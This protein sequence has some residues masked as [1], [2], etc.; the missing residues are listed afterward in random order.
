MTHDTPM[1]NQETVFA[2]LERLGIAYETVDC[3]PEFADTASFCERYD[4]ALADS[5]NT[6]VVAS[7]KP[8]GLFAA[9]VVLATTRLDVNRV[10]RRRLGA[11]RASFA[12][13]EQTTQITGMMIGG[14]TPPGLPPGLPLWV[15]QRVMERSRVIIGAGSRSKKILLPPEGFLALPGCEV[16]EGLAKDPG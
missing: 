5:A 6:I 16:V 7:R 10:V 13:A 15:D 3:D 12:T 14:V 2:T 9:C 4:F 1:K 11:S 8:A